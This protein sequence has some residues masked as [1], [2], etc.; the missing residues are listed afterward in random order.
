[1][2]DEIFNVAIP[3]KTADPLQ[4]AGNS[5]YL[6]AEDDLLHETYSPKDKIEVTFP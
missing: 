2:S 1:M 4:K 3:S 5:L 6:A